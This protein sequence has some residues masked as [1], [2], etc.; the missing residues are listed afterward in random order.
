MAVFN[1]K[2][3]KEMYRTGRIIL[4]NL[5]WNKNYFYRKI[6]IF[7]GEDKSPGYSEIPAYQS[8]DV[9]TIERI[10]NRELNIKN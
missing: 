1:K 2:V 4:L 6:S 10:K 8:K 5:N 3:K 7:I 9:A